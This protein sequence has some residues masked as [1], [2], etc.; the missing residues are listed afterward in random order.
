MAK[1][2]ILDAPAELRRK[3]DGFDGASSPQ[4]AARKCA[5]AAPA[6]IATVPGQLPQ[7][8]QQELRLGAC[9]RHQVAGDGVAAVEQVLGCGEHLFLGDRLQDVRPSLDVFDGKAYRQRLAVA[10]CE[11]GDVVERIDVGGADLMRTRSNRSSSTPS[12]MKSA[13]A[14]SSA[15]SASSSVTPGT[16]T[17][18]RPKVVSSTES[19][20]RRPTCRARVAH[21]T[22]AFRPGTMWLMSLREFRENAEDRCLALVAGVALRREIGAYH[23]GLG[24]TW[25]LECQA[26]LGKLRRL[27]RSD[28]GLERGVRLKRAVVP[29]GEAQDLFGSDVSRD[30]EG[31]VV[32]RVVLAVE[33]LGVG[34]GQLLLFH[35]ASRSPGYRKGETDTAPPVSAP[36]RAS[37]DRSPSAAPAPQVS[38][39]ARAG[40]VPR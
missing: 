15:A 5:G 3:W 18:T 28:A 22:G 24:H 6:V 21:R 23:V 39:R 32:G 37:R 29:F 7:G 13:R 35:V 40:P 26:A 27:L 2:I 10:T 20:S 33:R 9:R 31:G 1:R 19:P 8:P 16:G 34:E 30:D 11:R 36:R 38:R 25:I 4:A 12:S 17:T 14:A